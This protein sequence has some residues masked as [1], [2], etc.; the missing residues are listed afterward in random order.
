MRGRSA[1]RLKHFAPELAILLS[2]IAIT[3]RSYE[4]EEKGFLE[5][6]NEL[7]RSFVDES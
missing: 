6:R 2:L 1:H 5:T 3:S 4:A 7:L